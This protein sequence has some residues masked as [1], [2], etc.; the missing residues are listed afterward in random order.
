VNHNKV[1]LFGVFEFG[2]YYTTKNIW[3]F[4]FGT[5]VDDAIIMLKT[6]AGELT[7]FIPVFNNVFK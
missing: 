2:F 7:W 5:S 6:N 4:V 3:P 1:V